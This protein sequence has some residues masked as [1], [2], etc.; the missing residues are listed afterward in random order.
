M[1]SAL[2]TREALEGLVSDALPMADLDDDFHL[3]GF[4]PPIDLTIEG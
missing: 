4:A 2:G 3:T 1:N